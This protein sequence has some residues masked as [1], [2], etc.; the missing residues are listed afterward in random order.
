MSV[1]SLPKDWIT[2]PF[3][4]LLFQNLIVEERAEI[5]AATLSAWRLVL[6]ILRSQPGWMESMLTQSVQLEWYAVL[7]MPLGMPLDVSS[8]YDPLVSAGGQDTPERHNVDKNMLTQDLA[9]VP[10]QIVL[11]AR[12]A[13]ATALAYIVSVWPINVRTS[14]LSSVVHANHNL[15]DPRGDIPTYPDALHRLQ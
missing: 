4:R 11:C 1:S 10:V 15:L 14:V 2:L 3:M 13:A 5:R 6:T 8:F 7:M 9:L 12:V